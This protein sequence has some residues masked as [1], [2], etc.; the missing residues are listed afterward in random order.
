MDNPKLEALLELWERLT[1]FR[2]NAIEHYELLRST[3]STDVAHKEL[4]IRSIA[5]NRSVMWVA[6][7]IET[8]CHHYG[9]PQVKLDWSKMPDKLP[10]HPQ[11]PPFD[12]DPNVAG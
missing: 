3:P 10:N 12:K 7:E 9:E 6:G 8:M 5:L 1:P 2:I 4:E 11:S